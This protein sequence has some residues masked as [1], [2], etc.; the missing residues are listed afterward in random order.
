MGYSDVWYSRIG[1]V[2]MKKTGCN[3]PYAA[4]VKLADDLVLRSKLTEPPFEPRVFGELQGVREITKVYNVEW[5]AC[6][7]PFPNKNYIIE[8]GAMHSPHRQNFS[9]CHEVAHTLLLDL[10]ATPSLQKIAC[11][12]NLLGE[13]KAE[14]SLCNIGAAE[15]LTPYD[16]FVREASKYS[17]SIDSI[18]DLS[19]V[20]GASFSVIILRIIKTKV[21]DCIFAYWKPIDYKSPEKG[22][23]VDR[24]WDFQ[25]SHKDFRRYT[26][27]QSASIFY[28]Y[29]TG[30]KTTGKLQINFTNIRFHVESIGM[31][32]KDNFY[33]FSL[34]KPLPTN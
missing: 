22:F 32:R 29:K 16:S 19:D 18:K 14:E 30:K 24:S 5:D 21:W 4:M 6:L 8:I 3:N 28:T 12:I 17:P 11:S 27:I 25:L 23:Y 26:K 31:G 34:I 13:K 33:V 9:C 7:I 2:L 15:L 10:L 1:K 20:F